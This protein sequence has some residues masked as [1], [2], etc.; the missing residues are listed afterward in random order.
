MLK[1]VPFEV[2]LV[3]EICPCCHKEINEQI[4]IPKTLTEKVCNEIK[5]VDGKAVGY[6]NEPCDEC[7][8]HIPE[9]VLVK[10][11]D[12]DKSGKTLSEVYYTGLSI[13][14]RR[15][16]LEN[17]IENYKQF[18]I[19]NLGFMF[20]EDATLRSLIKDWKTQNPDLDLPEV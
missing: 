8:E 5:E 3:H 14:L 10:A 4:I 11:I 16:L 6:A 15:E 7:K 18:E 13:W 12:P 9:Y 2:A 1:Q 19:G 17:M 20:M